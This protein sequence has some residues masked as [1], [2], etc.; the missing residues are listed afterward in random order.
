MVAE[1]VLTKGGSDPSRLLVIDL[2]RR[3]AAAGLVARHDHGEHAGFDPVPGQPGG[4]HVPGL[5]VA[6]VG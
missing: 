5:Y 3:A 4:Q 6:R 2:W 1:A